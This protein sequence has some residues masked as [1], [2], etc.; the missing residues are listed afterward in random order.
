MRLLIYAAAGGL[1]A[2]PAAAG[3]LLVA[4]DLPRLNVSEYHR[5]YVAA[6]LESADQRVTNLAVW[7]DVAKREGE[8][9]KWLKDM[10][11]WWR[12][13]GRELTMP[14]DGLSGATRP[15]GHHELA[16]KTD[17]PV[18]AGLPAGEYH[19]VV[20]AAREVGGREL[21]RVPFRWPATAA[22]KDG[23]KGESELAAVTIELKP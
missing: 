19:L 15:P 14:V 1:A 23:A 9:T 21:L 5:P 8:G 22:F 6:W 18:L 7:Y 11:T 20:E 12:R 3:D 10:R 17:A 16:F 13:S 2:A 4:V